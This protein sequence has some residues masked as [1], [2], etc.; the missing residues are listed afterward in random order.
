MATEDELE[1]AVFEGRGVDA[2]RFRALSLE[3]LE[4]RPEPDWVVYR[5][6]PEDCVA[7]LEG[8]T[9]SLKTFVALGLGYSVATG[10][11]WLGRAVKQGRVLY[12]LGEGSR[13]LPRRA[14]A[15]QIVNLG[16]PRP[17]DSMRFVIDQMPQLWKGDSA[18]VL[19]SNP[20]GWRL[21][22]VDTLARAMLGGD[23]NLQ[24][25][26]GLLV[27]GCDLL[28]RETG[29][30]VLVLHHLNAAGNSRGSTALPA[31]IHTQLRMSREPNS[32]TAT[33]S[34]IKQ[35]D[36]AT[37]PPIVLVTRVVELGRLDEQGEAVTSLVL[38]SPYGTTSMTLPRLNP[39]EL[40]ALA[41]LEPKP[42]NFSEWKS[43]SG[44]ALTTFRRAR[45]RLVEAGY[46][47][48]V[49]ALYSISKTGEN[50]F[51]AAKGQPGA[52]VEMALGFSEEPKGHT[53]IRGG[54]W[55]RTLA[56]DPGRN[57]VEP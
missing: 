21:I 49:V 35:K 14:R 42:L 15:W 53:P 7:L 12:L 1:F 39:H 33:L 16:G 22:V 25:D 46:V 29:A 55:P 48:H 26:M 38:E 32:R 2:V 31:G 40:R 6:I 56:P 24:K 52:N 11:P 47:Q 9:T 3:D 54:P 5:V 43:Q 41:V 44:L 57:G 28:R 45:T 36:D 51:R 17:V 8:V 27:E 10:E 13:G 4:Q 37:E 19:A 23:E 20:G 30:C 34:F 50:V 18:A